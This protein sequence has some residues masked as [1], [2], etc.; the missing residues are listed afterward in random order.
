L[1]RNVQN[2]TD[3]KKKPKLLKKLIND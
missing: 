1:I 3:E 2:Q